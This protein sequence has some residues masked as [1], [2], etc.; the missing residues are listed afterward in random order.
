[1]QWTPTTLLFH[2][3]WSW[4]FALCCIGEAMLLFGIAGA[5]TGIGGSKGPDAPAYHF[6]DSLFPMNPTLTLAIAGLGS[7]SS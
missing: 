1:M 6:P 3:L 4:Q 2:F 5:V 7:Y